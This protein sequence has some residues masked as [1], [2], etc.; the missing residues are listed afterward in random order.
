MPL[1]FR[2]IVQ[3]TF[4]CTNRPVELFTIKALVVFQDAWTEKVFINY[5]QQTLLGDLL[6]GDHSVFVMCPVLC[7]PAG[8]L[9]GVCSRLAA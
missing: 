5:K 2:A 3:S 8:V 7:C 6:S 9:K 1:Q 4:F